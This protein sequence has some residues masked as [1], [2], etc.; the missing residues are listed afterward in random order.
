VP[1]AQWQDRPVKFARIFAVQEAA[2][3]QN[4]QYYAVS[5]SEWGFTISL[6]LILVIILVISLFGG[7]SGRFSEEVP[8][9]VRAARDRRSIN[10]Q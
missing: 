1:A 6:G 7:F 9:F 5:G 8:H 10:C 2:A 4:V 3:H